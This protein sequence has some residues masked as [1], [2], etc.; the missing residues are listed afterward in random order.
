[1]HE[2]DRRER[3]RAH[4]SQRA[5]RRA[6]PCRRCRRRAARA[7][8]CRARSR[9]H[10]RPSGR[11]RIGG[12]TELDG[13]IPNSGMFDPLTSSAPKNAPLHAFDVVV[14]REHGVR[15][16]GIRV[17]VPGAGR[18][19]RHPSSSRTAAGLA[20]EV[21]HARAEGHGGHERGHGDGRTRHDRAH[22]HGVPA[23]AR[24]RRETRDRSPPSA[25]AS[26]SRSA[27]PRPVAESD[28][29]APDAVRRFPP[30]DDADPANKPSTATA[31]PSRGPSSRR[32]TRSRPRLAA[33]DRSASAGDASNATPTASSAPTTTAIAGPATEAPVIWVGS[34]PRARAMS[35]CLA[36]TTDVPA[37]RLADQDEARDPD[38]DPE[39]SRGRATPDGSPASAWKVSV[40]VTRKIWGAAA[41]LLGDGLLDRGDVGVAVAEHEALPRVESRGPSPL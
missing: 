37:Q 13:S 29:R 39:R 11:R 14:R 12:V 5:R 32:R 4:D 41:R 40:E 38:D 27:R 30:R 34:A 8:R 35:R 33:P 22:G 3:R 20:D 16:R 18:R 10:A 9:P 1:M 28:R 7:W 26:P 31:H 2:A 21:L 36:V 25:A 15:L 23:A 24:A 17:A 19:A 6:A